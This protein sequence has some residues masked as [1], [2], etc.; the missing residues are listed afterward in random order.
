ML[1]LV[2]TRIPPHPLRRAGLSPGRLPGSP[3]G[4]AGGMRRRLPSRAPV[5]LSVFVL[6]GTSCGSPVAEPPPGDEIEEALT[7]SLPQAWSLSERQ[8]SQAPPGHGPVEPSGRL[9]VLLG[10]G[11][12]A[13]QWKDESG[14]WHSEELA[15]ET[16]EL[17][18][19]PGAYRP[20][21]KRFLEHHRHVPPDLVYASDRIRAYGRVSHRIVDEQRFDDLLRKA[22]STSWSDIAEKRC[23]WTGWS[24]AIAASLGAAFD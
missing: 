3:F 8:E 10:P 6:L 5:A 16:L 21:P 19:M 17:W 23:T 1:G 4:R 22:Y 7:S 11:P 18:V 2:E 20:S 12:V 13:F 24:E 15:R 9:Y 14:A